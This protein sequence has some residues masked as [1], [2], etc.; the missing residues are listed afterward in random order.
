MSDQTQSD[1]TQ[2]DQSAPEDVG[3]DSSFEES[4]G[5]T[6]DAAMGEETKATADVDP[7]AAASGTTESGDVIGA[8][9]PGVASDTVKD[10]GDWVTGD[11]PM[12]G[13]QRS[14]LD[15]LARRA[16]EQLPAELSKAEASE[17]IVRLQTKTGSGSS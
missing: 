8:E 16:G 14:Y 12:T 15:T 7:H 6:I 9:T 11:E 17:H 2:Q 1:Q 3:G 13:A 10:P 5:R 4:G